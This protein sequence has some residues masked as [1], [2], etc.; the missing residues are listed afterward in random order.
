MLVVDDQ[1]DVAV[2]LGDAIEMIGQRSYIAFDATTALDLA[3]TFAPD[4]ALLDLGL[5]DLDG[6]ELG[7]RLRARHGKQ[8]FL[9]AV[10]AWSDEVHRTAAAAAGFHAYLVKPVKIADI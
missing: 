10:T 6:C 2:M 1:E 9:V 3:E 4:V 8:L 7:R 5:P